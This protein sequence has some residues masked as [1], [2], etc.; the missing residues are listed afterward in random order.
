MDIRGYVE[1]HA[2]NV[3][4]R[5]SILRGGSTARSN[6]ALVM[7][8]WGAKNLR[9]EDSTL[10]AMNPSLHVDGVSGAGFTARRLDI[11]GVVD[12][13]KVIGSGVTVENSWLHDTL[14]STNDP[15][16][17]DGRT[18]D[19]S[20]QIEGG[21]GIVVRGNV[22]EDAHNAAIQVT[23]NFSATTSVRIEGNVISDG[24]CTLN[25]T[26]RGL[27][28]PIR[29]MTVSNNRFG[30]GSEGTRCPMLLPASSP[31]AVSGNVWDATGQKATPRWF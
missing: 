4:I 6:R 14:H 23:Q 25:V 18:H 21:S 31:I 15:N 27:G 1:V 9:I 22:L 3:V 13:V 10:V 20:I 7:S 30:S 2:D 12:A 26:E 24:V 29:G 16:Q 17:K 8:W 19:D 5:R 28:A 11:S